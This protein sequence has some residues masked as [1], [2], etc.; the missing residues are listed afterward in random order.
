MLE[1]I[2]SNL[3]FRRAMVGLQRTGPGSPE[4]SGPLSLTILVGSFHVLTGAGIHLDGFTLVDE[5][6][7][8]D[9]CARLQSCGLGCTL[10]GIAFDARLTLCDLEDDLLFYFERNGAA[11]PE[12]NRYRSIFD[13]P[14]GHIA[15]RILSTITCS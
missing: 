10:S 8:V 2:G 3:I 11:I 14:L 12:Q 7:Y 5:E 4:L 9:H 6:R 15:Y 1:R 13:E